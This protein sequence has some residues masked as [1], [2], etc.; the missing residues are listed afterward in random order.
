MHKRTDSSG[1]LA[2]Q[3]QTQTQADSEASSDGK[4]H[5]AQARQPSVWWTYRWVCVALVVLLG[6]LAVLYTVYTVNFLVDDMYEIDT[7]IRGQ[8]KSEK[9][10][11]RYK[12]D[13]YN[14]YCFYLLYRFVGG[15]IFA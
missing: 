8:Y 3:A 13:I 1:H 9:F 7:G 11:I 12:R 15:N 4:L 10:T 2:A 5:G 14:N 6:V